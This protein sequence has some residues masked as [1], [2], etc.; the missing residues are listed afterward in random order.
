MLA[1]RLRRRSNIGPTTGQCLMFTGCGLEVDNLL[2]TI[3]VYTTPYILYLGFHIDLVLRTD[4]VIAFRM[5]NN[6]HQKDDGI[7]SLRQ[8]EC[9]ICHQELRGAR[10]LSCSHAVCLACGEEYISKEGC[11]NHLVCSTCG[12]A[13]TTLRRR[14][15]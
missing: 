11:V 7:L 12:Q 3:H 13:Y 4:F 6:S 2:I 9:C 10:L 1:R 8:D 15:L 14:R 5:E